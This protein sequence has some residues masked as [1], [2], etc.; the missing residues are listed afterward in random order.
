M[1]QRMRV[2]CLFRAF[3]SWHDGTSDKS[4]A[5]RR[6]AQA[7]AALMNGQLRRCWAS[8][9]DFVDARLAAKGHMLSAMAHWR[10][11]IAMA[12]FK[13]WKEQMLTVRIAHQ[14]SREVLMRMM[15]KLKACPRPIQS[16]KYFAALHN[17]D[18]EGRGAPDGLRVTEIVPMAGGYCIA[19]R[20]VEQLAGSC[21][22]TAGKAQCHASVYHAPAAGQHWAPVQG[23]AC[24]M[25]AA[26]CAE[27]HS[28]Q[29]HSAPATSAAEQGV[30][31]M[32]NFPSTAAGGKVMHS[33]VPFPPSGSMWA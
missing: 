22:S 8:W 28:A 11:R 12:C 10:E 27:S 1:I 5:K 3:S 31:S 25:P 18:L 21:N 32:G 17:S 24:R 23:M 26:C 15:V 29:M 20:G 6:L 16:P 13:R 14:R 9:L 2:S 4:A 19:G 30:C 33:L 7:V